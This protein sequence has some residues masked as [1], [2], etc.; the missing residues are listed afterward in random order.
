MSSIVFCA[1]ASEGGAVLHQTVV[2]ED[3]LALA[4]VPAR[5]QHAAVLIDDACR[6]RRVGHVRAV[7][8]ETEDEKAT[9]HHEDDGLNP[10]FRDQKR[11]SSALLHLTPLRLG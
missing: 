5:E 2:Q 9:Q 4:D 8:E 10:A 7:G 1:A 3:L 11:T 6:H